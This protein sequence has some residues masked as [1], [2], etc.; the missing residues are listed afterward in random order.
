MFPV[1]PGDCEDF[2]RD[3]V[4]E[5]QR[6]GLAQTAYRAGTLRDK[7]GLAYPANRFSADSHV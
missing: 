1:L 7:L 2:V 6:R 4:P 5:L 3:V